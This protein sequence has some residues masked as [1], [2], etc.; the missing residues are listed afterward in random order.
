MVFNESGHEMIMKRMR[1]VL[2]GQAMFIREDRFLEAKDRL[3]QMDV[4]E[5]F[6]DY[7]NNYELYNQIIEEYKE[8]GKEDVR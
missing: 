6:V 7:I 2:K 1:N 3:E 5:H 8:R 4:I